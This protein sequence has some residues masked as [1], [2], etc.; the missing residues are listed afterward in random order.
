MQAVLL[1]LRTTNMHSLDH[2][3]NDPAVG[4]G[5]DVASVTNVLYSGALF[6]PQIRLRFRG[7]PASRGRPPTSDVSAEVRVRERGGAGR[8]SENCGPPAGWARVV[9][10]LQTP[11]GWPLA[12]R[13]LRL[14]G[15]L[16]SAVLCSALPVLQG[17]SVHSIVQPRGKPRSLE[18]GSR[19]SQLAPPAA[20][21]LLG[22]AEAD[23][24]WLWPWRGLAAALSCCRWG[25]CWSTCASSS[26]PA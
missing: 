13:F 14:A 10:M 16:C 18:K 24:L 7:D 6:G 21:R 19:P 26:R 23:W 9:I 1:R 3:L 4:M 5:R 2:L 17:P 25:R 15:V 22:T 11:D 8:G 12:S 20:R